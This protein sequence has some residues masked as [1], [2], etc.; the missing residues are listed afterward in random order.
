MVAIILG[1]SMTIA[2]LTLVNLGTVMGRVS[3][4]STP[5]ALDSSIV[6]AS[7]PPIGEVSDSFIEDGG[8]NSCLGRYI[9]ED[10]WFK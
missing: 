5:T 2:Q 3:S 8:R 1:V 4:L 7:F 9:I 10:V 6:Q